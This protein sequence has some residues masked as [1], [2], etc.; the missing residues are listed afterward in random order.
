MNARPQGDRELKT[1]LSGGLQPT[2]NDGTFYHS[3][4]PRTIL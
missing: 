4:N 2:V 3:L 1:V